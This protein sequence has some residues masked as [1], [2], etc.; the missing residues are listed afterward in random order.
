[1]IKFELLLKSLNSI[2]TYLIII[3]FLLFS[4]NC[5]SLKKNLVPGTPV[6]E[7]GSRYTVF[8]SENDGKKNSSNYYSESIKAE[9][10]IIEE[11][12][13][14][15]IRVFF[16]SLSE[17]LSE[18][19]KKIFAGSLPKFILRETIFVGLPIRKIE[20]DKF[21][22][23][24]QKVYHRKS[25]G[26]DPESLTGGN[27]SPGESDEI[28][29]KLV[30]RAKT[31]VSLWKEEEWLVENGI[32][33]VWRNYDGEE[34]LLPSVSVAEYLTQGGKMYSRIHSKSD[35]TYR[36]LPTEEGFIP[37]LAFPSGGVGWMI[38]D[39]FTRED[40]KNSLPKL[41][42]RKILNPYGN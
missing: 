15:L 24:F 27:L 41:R 2:E 3:Y 9:F 34:L 10:L 38:E 4:S 23:N 36:I 30:F 29:L 39:D 5:L 33:R 11:K 19:I 16:G 26:P 7:G 12:R 22:V 21:V 1:M 40:Q 8:R 32:Q 18:Q 13:T 6:G 31:G 25:M 17:G 20:R 28:L 35:Y 37:I 14:L 42:F